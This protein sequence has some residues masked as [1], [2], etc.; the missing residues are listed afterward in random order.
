M[1]YSVS[2]CIPLR[3]P[4][5]CS[6]SPP[7]I[8]HAQIVITSNPVKTGSVYYCDAQCT[9]TV[10]QTYDSR[11]TSYASGTIALCISS[12]VLESLYPGRLYS[13]TSSNA[14][15][16][17]GS[18]LYC[19]VA[20]KDSGSKEI[21]FR[22]TEAQQIGWTSKP[23]YVRAMLRLEFKRLM[24]AWGEGGALLLALLSGSREYLTK[25]VSEGFT[26]AGLSHILAL[27]GMHLSF[28]AGLSKKVSKKITGKRLSCLLSFISILFFVWFAGF[29]PSLLRA[30]LCSVC[31]LMCSVCYIKPHT[32][33]LL[34]LCFII[35]ICISPKDG[36][37]V[38]FLL[39]Y[40]ALLGITWADKI[41]NKHLIT[42]VP[43]SLSSSLSASIG[44]QIFTIPISVC[45]FGYITPVGIIA[46]VII[47][48]LIS[49]F[50]IAGLCCIIATLCMPSLLMP[51][52]SVIGGLYEVI[53][54]LV[55]LFSK[56]PPVNL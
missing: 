26:Y 1:Y 7:L 55:L 32:P 12:E 31:L 48:P 11:F 50:L 37:C 30:F 23:S 54:F 24:Y 9:K 19:S 20:Y 5:V 2:P 51:L 38:S 44:A 28:F 13:K 42:C 27:S 8:S 17:K 41:V 15:F 45:V 22:V 40:A 52:S 3:N 16:E 56:I 18:I 4:F 25:K 33:S 39:S 43:P 21:M 53:C 14:V 6:I 36:T 47:S 34:A 46:A 29:S 10:S 49:L 35:Q